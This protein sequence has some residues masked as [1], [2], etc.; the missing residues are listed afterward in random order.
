M[1]TRLEW[2][3]VD[4][5]AS[6]AGVSPNAIRWAIRRCA[7]RR[8]GQCLDSWTIYAE[9]QNGVWRVPVLVRYE[10]TVTAD[11]QI[12]SRIISAE[13]FHSATAFAS[14]LQRTAREQRVGGG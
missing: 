8:W 11:N 5:V 14:Y 10:T 7:R 6:S 3:S 9:K 1:E 2:W 12:H 4:E 13:T